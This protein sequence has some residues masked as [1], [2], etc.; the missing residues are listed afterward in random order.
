MC[1]QVLHVQGKDE[2]DQGLDGEHVGEDHRQR[3][4]PPQAQAEPQV[5]EL[6]VSAVRH[7]QDTGD[8]QDR[9]H[10]RQPACDS[11]GQ[12]PH[13]QGAGHE[14]YGGMKKRVHGSAFFCG[15]WSFIS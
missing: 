13:D 2:P 14:E 1:C 9:G 7:G 8:G 11:A 15:P 4:H 12:H 5:G 10:R 3:I 6:H